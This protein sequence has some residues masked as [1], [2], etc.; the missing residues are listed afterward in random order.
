L[1]WGPARLD[2]Y[3]NVALFA[4]GL[5]L[6]TL[7]FVIGA[8]P[9]WLIGVGAWDAV[10]TQVALRMGASLMLLSLV[11]RASQRITR[12]PHIFGAVAQET[13][14]IYFVHLCIVYGSI[15]NRGLAQIYGPT[16]GP[17]RTVAGVVLL[18]AAM[19]GLASYWNW[20]KHTRPR[21][22]RW[23]AWGV[24]VLLGYRLL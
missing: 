18:L 19:V 24:G 1:R 17:G 4:P 14:L 5:G 7:A 20:W 8:L 15:W 6:V 2:W 9:V 10:P 22:A 12:L 21:L 13:L 3:A 23:T 16:L 11:A